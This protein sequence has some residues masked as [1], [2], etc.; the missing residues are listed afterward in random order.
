MLG[1][2]QSN[3]QLQTIKIHGEQANI[4]GELLGQSIYMG[5]YLQDANLN[6]ASIT[7]QMEQV[8]RARI[9][10]SSA[11]SGRLFRNVAQSDLLGRE[12]E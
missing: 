7:Q 2:T 4:V 3:L 1:Y 8:N 10:D 5:Q 9:I 12:R 11:E 6:L